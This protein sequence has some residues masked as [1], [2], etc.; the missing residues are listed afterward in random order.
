MQPPE[1]PPVCTALKLLALRHPPADGEDDVAQGDAHRHF[2]QARVVDLAD[3][4]EDLG[5]L[6]AAGADAREPVRA[7]VDDQGHGRPG[8]DVVE[9]GRP[10]VQAA[11]GGV[12]VLGPGA[13]HPALDGG[14]QRR[15]FSAH[16]GARAA[17][18]LDREGVAAA[19][20]VLAEQAVL[21]RLP[22]CGLH[23]LHGQRVL[24]AHVEVPVVA[25]DGPAADDHALDHRVR[26][27]LEHGPVHVR[28]GV[29]LVGVAD[30]VAHA[31]RETAPSP[32]SPTCG[33]RGS[34]RRRGR[35]GRTSSSPRSPPPA[36]WR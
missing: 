19:E 12:H 16:E 7:P 31:V 28:A 26:V 8:L 4:R 20:D 24:G 36:S 3:E 10:L 30:D 5:A 35:A 32:R 34:P 23:V 9:V 21:L 17:H 1:G 14:H 6:A 2:H 15:G 33:P 13:A 25:A 11:V 29:A 18:H 27:G 22:Q